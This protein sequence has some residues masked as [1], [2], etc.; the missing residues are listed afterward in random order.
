MCLP[1]IFSQSLRKSPSPCEASRRGKGI[2][3]RLQ[4]P[5]P[6]LL[7]R[8]FPPLRA[9]LRLPQHRACPLQALR[10]LPVL[11]LLALPP[12]LNSSDAAAQVE[13]Q[14]L[15][16]I[17]GTESESPSAPSR[18]QVLSPGVAT[19]TSAQESPLP[20][21]L[22]SATDAPALERLLNGVNSP[23]PSPVLA[24]LIARALAQGAGDGSELAIRLNALAKAG[25]I[26]EETALLG[27]AMQARE[28]GAAALY[29]TALLEAGRAD[30]ACAIAIEPPPQS[31]AASAR[32]TRAAFLVPAYCAA[33]KGDQPGANLALQLAR[34]RGVQ[35]PV[36]FAAIERL[37]NAS[38]KPIALP[39]SLDS[40]DYLFLKLDPRS[41]PA[42]LAANAS[43]ATLFLIAHDDHAPPGLR[44]AAAE[45][46]ASLNVIDGATLAKAYRDVAP[47]LTK[48]ATPPELRAKLFAA[49][50]AAPTAKIKAESIDA[51]LASG[52]DA[53][54]EIPLGVAL[55]PARASL[56]ADPQ[57]SG[58]AETALRVAILAGDMQ[59]AWAWIDAG[60]DK[61][62]LWQLLLAAAD[63]SDPRT[64]AA[65]AEGVEIAAIGGLPGPFLHR[66]LAVLDAL[67]YDV[68]IPLWDAASKTEQ[69]SDGYLPE[70]GVLS[71]LKDA[72]DRG[73]VG[74]TVLLAAAALGPKGP[75]DA[76][77]LALGDAVRAIKRVGLDAEAR[78]VGFEALY[79]HMP[80]K[81]KG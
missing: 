32:P 51:L 4:P 29:A 40:F 75:A 74:R 63:P 1:N 6:L 56:A 37:G 33:V 16:A 53:R 72:S 81:K 76:N 21:D 70:T 58:Y 79:A 46:A 55:Q 42:S 54:I 13:R 12:S 39:K 2:C 23:S 43:P 77:L 7:R 59:A 18:P 31:V 14:E 34:D 25:R 10:T 78:R 65:L 41:L 27:G 36:P 73:A 38:S 69:P 19:G 44:L 20:S 64:E 61:L 17:P 67:D 26:D 47:K 50:E 28:P 35:A 57:A 49:L 62:K 9:L 15:P 11:L 5:S 3:L 24:T 60:G 48:A 30:E 80:Q 68:P 71:Q 8:R 45:R 22:W 66:L 52:R